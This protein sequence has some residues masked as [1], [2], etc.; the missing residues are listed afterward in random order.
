MNLCNKVMGVGINKAKF[1]RKQKSM[2][3]G[4]QTRRQT[5][6]NM[7]K[8]LDSL[9]LYCLIMF[10]Y[11]CFVKVDEDYRTQNRVLHVTTQAITLLLPLRLGHNYMITSNSNLIRVAQM[12]FISIFPQI[13][14]YQNKFH[15]QSCACIEK[16]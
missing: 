6:W 13:Y 4:S 12:D 11:T 3:N 7:R 14:Y 1:R 8:M 5:P 9:N 2:G 10:E 16:Y 15:V